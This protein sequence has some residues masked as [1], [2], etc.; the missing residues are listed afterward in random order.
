MALLSR[1]S[2]PYSWTI[3]EAIDLRFAS[4][5]VI[6][7]FLFFSVLFFGSQHPCLL[8]MDSS[9]NTPSLNGVD[10]HGHK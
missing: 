6:P 10:R 5:R 9:Y 1:P 8:P 3:F 2:C 7:V 4:C